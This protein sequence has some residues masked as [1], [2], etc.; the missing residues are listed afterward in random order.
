MFKIESGIPLP[1]IAAKRL[2]GKYDKALTSL[3][4]GDSFFIPTR[5]DKESKKVRSTVR[6]RCLVLFGKTRKFA[7]REV[8]NG[9]RVWRVEDKYTIAAREYL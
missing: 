5:D 4:L 1:K 3:N 9:I 2:V 7:T 6:S 8:K